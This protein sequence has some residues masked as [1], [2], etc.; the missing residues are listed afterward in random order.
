MKVQEITSNTILLQNAYDFFGGEA[1]KVLNVMVAT[2]LVILIIS[3]D[4]VFFE[5]Q[6]LDKDTSTEN[7]VFFMFPDL[8]EETAVIPVEEPVA[9]ED[10]P[11]K[12]E[13]I[14]EASSS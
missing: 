6:F 5:N 13:V 1:G 7:S 8:E 3:R 4:A 14:T 9:A 2:S 12:E 10:V 11:L